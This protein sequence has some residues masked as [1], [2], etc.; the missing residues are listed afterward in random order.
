MAPAIVHTVKNPREGVAQ[1][2][3]IKSLGEGG[4]AYFL[5]KSGTLLLYRIFIYNFLI[6]LKGGHMSPRPRT[7]LS[8]HL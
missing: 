1:I 4:G 7:P 3:L 5:D 8:L 6:R 2:F